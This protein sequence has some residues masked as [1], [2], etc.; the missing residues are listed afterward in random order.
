MRTLTTLPTTAGI[1]LRAPHHAE[2]LLD[3]PAVAW[4]EVHSENFFADGGPALDFL[5]AI[6]ADYPLSLHGVGAS[7]GGVDSLFER[8][9]D[10]LA[11][12]AEIIEP[13]AI[14]EHLCWSSVG[15]QHFNDLLPLPSTEAAVVQAVQRI[16]RMQ[17]RL[18]R[19][20]LIENVSSY[21]QWRAA[22]YSEWDFL[23]EVARRAGCG[24]L[25]DVNNIHVSASNHGFD[26]RTYVDAVPPELVGEIHLAGYDQCEDFL[27]DT[28]GKRVHPPV[29]ELYEY[30]LARLGLRPTLIEWDTD[31][32]PLDV[33]QDEAAHADRYLAR[34]AAVEVADA[35]L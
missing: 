1:G 21:V 34:I 14:S 35:A 2:V 32:P 33:L 16:E 10:R 28:H 23:V 7:L 12:L 31:I 30:T 18:Q 5:R 22:D 13:A 19:T 24:I 9:L 20:L 15:D 27:V 11:R 3:R 6:R 26:A 4:W 29:W 8:H 25:L 17:E